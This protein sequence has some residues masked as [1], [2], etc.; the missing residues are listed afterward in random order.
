[1][2]GDVAEHIE[3]AGE[4]QSK[5]PHEQFFARQLVLA[6]ARPGDGKQDRPQDGRQAKAD[7]VVLLGPWPPGKLGQEKE[8]IVPELVHRAVT[9]R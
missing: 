3:L 9:P 4:A 8:Y 6:L 1:L 2:K 7:E 5:A